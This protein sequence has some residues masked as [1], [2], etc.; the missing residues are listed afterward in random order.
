MTSHTGLQHN[1]LPLFQGQ[2]HPRSFLPQ[3]PFEFQALSVFS[4]TY[5]LPVVE[6][7]PLNA[8]PNNVPWFLLY[9]GTQW[10]E[11]NFTTLVVTLPG[12]PGLSAF[13]G[14]KNGGSGSGGDNWRYTA[15]KAPVKS[16]PSTN[17]HPMFYRPD[18]LLSLRL[19]DHFNRWT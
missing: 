7:F 5:Y 16:S 19:N 14:A 9:S 13:S 11:K 3:I 2:D 1:D 18:A 10:S 6:V 12:E 4:E 17:Q 15:C 8:S